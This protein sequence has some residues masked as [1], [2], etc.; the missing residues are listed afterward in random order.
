MQVEQKLSSHCGEA[1]GDPGEMQSLAGQGWGRRFCAF[2]TSQSGGSRLRSVGAEEQGRVGHTPTAQLCS[3]DRGT[4]PASPQ[5][6]LT[7]KEASSCLQH[8]PLCDLH[9]FLFSITN[10]QPK[11]AVARPPTLGLLEATFGRDYPKMWTTTLF[12]STK[13]E[14]QR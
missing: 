1:L 9:R 4:T 13:Q 11:Q 2:T 12:V 6:V 8:P 10:P 3:R 7:A 14:Q 5:A